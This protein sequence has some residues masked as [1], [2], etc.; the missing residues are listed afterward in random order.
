MSTPNAVSEAAG[1]FVHDLAE[2]RWWA[3][4][5]FRHD[6]GVDRADRAFRRW[7]RAIARDVVRDH[8]T[9]AW[10][11]GP[12]RFGRPHFH[13]LLAWRWDSLVYDADLGEQLWRW[14]DHN[15]GH[16]R[17]ERYDRDEGAA[18]YQAAHAEWDVN[19][20]CPRSPRCRRNGPCLLA[21]GSW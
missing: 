11:T 1:R 2:W 14:V 7:L 5:T 12:Q 13:V 4:L 6:I 9:V 21:P 17:V 19:L 15:A 18:W 3:T 8:V 20:V 10:A 16:A